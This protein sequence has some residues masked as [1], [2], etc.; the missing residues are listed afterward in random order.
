M[1]T[2]SNSFSFSGTERAQQINGLSDILFDLIIIGGGVTGAGIALDASLRGLKVLLLEKTDFAYGT[3]SRSTKLIHGGLRYLKQL[4][5]KL[6]SE[7]GK[8]R[9]IVHKI[10]PQLAI[11]E[12]MLLPLYKN[13]TYGKLST[14]LGLWVYDLVAGVKGKDKRKMLSYQKT[15]KKEPLLKLDGLLGGGYYAEYRTDDARLTL[16]LIKTAVSFGAICLNHCEATNFLEHNG[17]VS[18]VKFTNVLDGTS[19]NVSGKVVVNATGPWVDELRKK[20]KSLHGKHLVWSKGIHIV[21]D[22]EKLPIKQAAY[23]DVESDGRMIFAIPRENCT[24]IGTTDTHYKDSLDNVATSFEEA[25]YL[26]NAINENFNVA[27]KIP[28]IKSSWAGVRPLIM[29]TG[30]SVKDISR[31]DEIF[32]APN[33]LLSIAGGKLTGYRKMAERVVDKVLRQSNFNDEKV[34]N[35]PST[36]SQS[37][38]ASNFENIK[39]VWS[40]KKIIKK[41]LKQ[42]NLDPNKAYYLV[43][44]YGKDAYKIIQNTNQFN[45]K[46]EVKLIMA[47]AK[48]CI[49]FEMCMTLSDFFVRRTGRLYFDID[50]VWH[51][52]NHV[53]QIFKKQYEWSMERIEIENKNLEKDLQ[54][55]TAFRNLEVVL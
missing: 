3:S 40:Y 25:N 37:L 41:S 27:I 13:G 52:R 54:K 33:G 21:V 53:L 46:N 10:A 29:E 24:Y 43:T 36:A 42:F 4:E 26:L 6:V 38:Y 35:K 50:S 17:E 11:P 47:E 51:H 28:D 44:R 2:Q 39:D 15:L 22:F 31:K 16:S 55:A 19:Q 45:E 9:A 49:D 5:F 12:K 23:F 1:E 34:F 32:I 20:N 18:G 8:E 14:A 48:Y 7:V 30:K